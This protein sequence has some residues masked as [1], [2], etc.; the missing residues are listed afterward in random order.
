MRRYVRY[1]VILLTAMVLTGCGEVTMRDLEMRGGRMFLRGHP[2][3]P[4]TGPVVSYYPS[5]DEDGE[6]RIYQTGTYTDGLR[7]DKWMTYYWNG[8]YEEAKYINSRIEGIR[9][10][11]YAGAN[12]KG[13]KRIKREQEYMDNMMD[14]GGNFYNTTGGKVKQVYYKDGRIIPYPN[15]EQRKA[16]EERRKQYKSTLG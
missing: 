3:H 10:W 8:E 11:F 13:K 14:G 5:P 4:Y 1:V 6:K 12:A 7:S 15:P 9:K 16:L 2:V